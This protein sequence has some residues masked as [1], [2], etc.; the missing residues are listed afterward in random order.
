[1]FGF[2][3]IFTAFR[4]LRSRHN[5]RSP[6]RLRLRRPPTRKSRFPENQTAQNLKAVEAGRRVKDVCREPGVI[7]Q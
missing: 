4:Q 7:T 3:C 5:R 6:G 2:C 1:M